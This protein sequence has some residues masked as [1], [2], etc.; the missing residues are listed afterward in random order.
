MDN[1]GGVEEFEGAQNLVDEVLDVLCEQLL[2]RA[3]H[4]AQVRLHQLANQVNITEHLSCL[5]DVDDVEEAE[6]VLMQQVFHDDDL[7]QH[8]L[9]I[10]QIF[11]VREL[12]NCDLFTC[13]SI[14]C[15]NDGA[16]SALSNQLDSLVLEG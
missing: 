3:D 8:A 1:V 14:F 15:G 16:V 13:L 11:H 12:L 4:S 9:C 6:H 7:S 10:D 5:W 2:S